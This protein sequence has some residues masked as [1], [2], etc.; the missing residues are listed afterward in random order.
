MTNIVSNTLVSILATA[1]IVQHE[2]SGWMDVWVPK[3]FPPKTIQHLHVHEHCRQMPV[4]QMIPRPQIMIPIV[5]H[6][7]PILGIICST[8]NHS[9]DKQPLQP[10][11]VNLNRLIQVLPT[12][13]TV[14]KRMA[15]RFGTKVMIGRP[16]EPW[17][18]E[19]SSEH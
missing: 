13:L 6:L 8:G 11:H 18:V 4:L 2:M 16:N 14:E 5:Y 19:E 10:S 15:L 9:R 7:W 1:L 12:V 3:L 17:K